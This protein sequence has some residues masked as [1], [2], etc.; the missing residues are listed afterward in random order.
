MINPSLFYY[1]SDVPFDIADK[2]IVLGAD[3]GCGN[4]VRYGDRI[5][6]HRRRLIFLF[7]HNYLP[8]A[9]FTTKPAR[10]ARSDSVYGLYTP[11]ET[12]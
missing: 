2:R 5:C 3:Y 10:I 8:E 11:S 6:G 12:A 9:Q 1:F 7:H 4:D